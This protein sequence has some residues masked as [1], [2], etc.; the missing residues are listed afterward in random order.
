MTNS[1]IVDTQY[2]KVQGIQNGP[3]SVWK[4][5]PYA[6]PPIGPLRFH[7]P[8][9]P[10]AWSSVRNA[11]QFGAIAPQTA[12][13]SLG[14]L[15]ETMSEDCLTLNIWSPGADDARR[16]VMVWLHGGAFVTGS[17]S[18]PWYEGTAFA[19]HGD[20][21]VV[22]LNYRLGA[23][24][25]LYL[26][27]YAGQEYASSGNNGLLDQIAALTWVRD[28]IAAF[29]GNPDNVTLFGESAGAM[30]I[31][32]L[33][34]IPAAQ[35]L[36]KRAILESG[37]AQR[38][39]SSHTAA[40]A[41]H[42]FIATLELGS[43]DIDKLLAMPVDTL[44]TVQNAMPSSIQLRSFCPVADG[45]VLPKP[46]IEAI[47]EGSAAG[48]DVLIGTNLDEMKLFTMFDPAQQN[49]NMSQLT[50]TFGD[51]AEEV[52][53]TYTAHQQ[54]APLST[55]WEA[56]LTDRV[57]RIPA[58]RIAEQQAKHGASVWM[59]RF[60]WPSPV[61]GGVLGACHA[62]EIPFVF[63]NL[64]QTG[65]AMLL[66]NNAPQAIANVM[67]AAWIAF[68]HNGDVTQVEGL[69]TWPRY[70][71]DQRAT[72]LF[73]NECVVGYDPQGTTRQLWEGAM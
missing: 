7:T 63:D 22:T 73:N 20:V 68:A 58:I 34:A 29:G 70:D 16:P 47:A 49:V 36:F 66:D 24:G 57:F 43:N 10:V 23:L 21:V 38:I 59:Y 62:L 56:L 50:R 15:S 67:H 60:D 2:G 53:A 31:G 44:L 8:Q 55:P 3:I 61:Y 65:T 64:G 33:L 69:P 6:Q 11:T 1:T 41:A 35:G 30:S 71:L 17:G 52:L 5:I 48:V 19:T 9:P 46:A 18:T 14:T 54:E 39:N 12:M 27:E 37:A 28:N 51:R 4:G 42:N 72:M 25:F 45:I 40:E 26:A 13:G 32:T